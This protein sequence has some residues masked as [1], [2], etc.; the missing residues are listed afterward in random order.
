MLIMIINAHVY[1]STLV[2]L[3]ICQHLKPTVTIVAVIAEVL[4]LPHVGLR[5]GKPAAVLL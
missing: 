5:A 3:E 2:P 4:L 1:Q